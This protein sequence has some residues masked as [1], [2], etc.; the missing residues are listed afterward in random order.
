VDMEKHHSCINTSV[1]IRY[2]E[3]Y[4]PGLVDKLLQH[5]GPEVDNL[6]DVKD[7]LMDPNNWVSGHVLIN[8]YGNAKRLLG[9]DVI[10]KIGFDSVIKKRL[11]YIQKI[12]FFALGGPKQAVKK[13]QTLNDK[14]NRSKTIH[15]VDLNKKGAILQLH[16]FRNV[17]LSEDFCSVNKGIYTAVPVIW[18]LPPAHLEETRCFFKGDECCEYHITWE[19]RSFLLKDYFFKA[20]SDDLVKSHAAILRP[21]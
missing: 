17:P 12:L 1:A 18:G 20:N 4:A 10:F 8:M 15:T 6:P 16:W 14:F 9:D 21:D 3:D 7:F 13:I 5:L 2:F 19:K 11:G